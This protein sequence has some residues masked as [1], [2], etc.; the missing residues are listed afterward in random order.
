M[1]TSSQSAYPRMTYH[2]HRAPIALLPAGARRRTR[3]TIRFS[4]RPSSPLSSRTSVKRSMMKKA[5]TFDKTNIYVRASKK[6]RLTH[7]KAIVADHSCACHHLATILSC[8]ESSHSVLAAPCPVTQ[9]STPTSLASATGLRAPSRDPPWST[10]P[11]NIIIAR[12]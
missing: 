4:R 9:A 12:S 1:T 8:M 5:S 7:A 6:A 11:T 2:R 10:C 3:A